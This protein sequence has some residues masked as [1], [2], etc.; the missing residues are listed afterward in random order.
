MKIPASGILVILAGAA[1]LLAPPWLYTLAS[2][3]TAKPQMSEKTLVRVEDKRTVFLD[4]V[5]GP[6]HI[7]HFSD[8]SLLESSTLSLFPAPKPGKVVVFSNGPKFS[9][10]EAAFL[11]Q[12]EDEMRRDGKLR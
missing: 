2:S 5:Y 7:Y 9:I 6:H 10:Y 4:Y 11:R 8:G 3:K 1:C 12:V